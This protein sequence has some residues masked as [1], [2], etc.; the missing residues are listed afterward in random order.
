MILFIQLS[1]FT[2]L[3]FGNIYKLNFGKDFE[4]DTDMM[5]LL[6]QFES[7]LENAKMQV[8]S[9]EANIVYIFVIRGKKL[10]QKYNITMIG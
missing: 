8:S 4:L 5:E 1:I 3:A 7:K 2:N 6:N 9:S 10:I